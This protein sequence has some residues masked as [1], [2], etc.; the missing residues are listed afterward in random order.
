M[1]LFIGS[2]PYD[3]TEDE[4]REAFAPFGEVRSVRIVVDRDTGRSKGFG[5]V[6]YTS[7]DAATQAVEEMNGSSLKGRSIVVDKARERQ[8]RPQRSHQGPR[9]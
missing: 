4:L 9:Y 7:D 5:F 8:D 3:L 1:K 6:E 2:L